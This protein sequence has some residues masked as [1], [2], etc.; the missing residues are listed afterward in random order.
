MMDARCYD[1]A[2]NILDDAMILFIASMMRFHQL[3]APLFAVCARVA[4]LRARR[5]IASLERATSRGLLGYAVRVRSL[6]VLERAIIMNEIEAHD[7]NAHFLARKCACARWIAGAARALDLSHEAYLALLDISSFRARRSRNSRWRLRA[8][9]ISHLIRAAS[10]SARGGSSWVTR[11]DTRARR[12]TRV[13]TRAVFLNTRDGK[14]IPILTHNMSALDCLDDAMICAI[15]DYLWVDVFIAPF[16]DCSA[17][18]RGALGKYRVLSYEPVVAGAAKVSARCPAILCA[19]HLGGIRANPKLLL[20]HGARSASRDV[21]ERAIEWLD[22]VGSRSF[23]ALICESTRRGWFD[24]CEIALDCERG[25][26]CF[27]GAITTTIGAAVRERWIRGL[28]ET[29]AR[30]DA[31]IIKPSVYCVIALDL[32]RARWREGCDIVVDWVSAGDAR[33]RSL[34]AREIARKSIENGWADGCT[35]ARQRE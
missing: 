25:G 33:R 35:W 31:A 26:D 27:V 20:I 28:L 13:A 22:S 9:M 1:S 17:R 34:F 29:F 2:I 24:G 4:S 18:T 12:N 8:S 6:D 14:N 11:C 19:H 21:V 3:A 10:R 30:V 32:V 15:A 5:E 7:L 23:V 16:R